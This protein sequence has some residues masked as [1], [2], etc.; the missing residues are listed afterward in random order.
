M[1]VSAMK[2]YLVEESGHLLLYSGR[3]RRSMIIPVELVG[4]DECFL[5]K[6]K[7]NNK[8]G[9]GRWESKVGAL[10]VGADPNGSSTGTLSA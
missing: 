3:R 6:D 1:I 4:L 7:N 9:G 8:E 10:M 5:M 2:P